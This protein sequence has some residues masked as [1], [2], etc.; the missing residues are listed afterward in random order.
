MYGLLL[1]LTLVLSCIMLAP[2]IQ[3]WIYT[4][5]LGI[6]YLGWF[7]ELHLNIFHPQFEKKRNWQ[8]WDLG[9]FF[10][11]NNQRVPW[12]AIRRIKCHRIWF[13]GFVTVKKALLIQVYIINR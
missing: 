11:K 8:F 12:K 10:A 9:F 5:Q 4:M 13:C 2:G 3:E 1:L 6:T 7:H